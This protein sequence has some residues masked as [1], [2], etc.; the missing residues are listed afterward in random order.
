MMLLDTEITHR[1]WSTGGD[2]MKKRLIFLILIAIAILTG[3]VL[4]MSK[5][6]SHNEIEKMFLGQRKEY[7]STWEFS[8]AEIDPEKKSVLVMFCPLKKVDDRGEAAGRIYDLL[9]SEYLDNPESKYQEYCFNI[10][11]FD[12]LVG[13]R[14]WI[15]EIVK[16]SKELFIENHMLMV[17]LEGLAKGF[18]QAT[19]LSLYP[20]RYQ[21]IT[22]ISGF[23]NLTY[24]ETSSSLTDEEIEYIHSLFPD[25]KIDVK[26]K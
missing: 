10:S 22:E 21:D 5:K 6:G 19:K 18:P 17:S 3:V 13:E 9:R 7:S 23:E 4:R 12:Q 24:L 2:N 14:L 25:C 8:H 16:D 1:M 26:V 15:P 20:M 11:F